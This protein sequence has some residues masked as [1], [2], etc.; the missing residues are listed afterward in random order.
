MVGATGFEPAT[1]PPP[2]SEAS[3]IFNRFEGL[4]GHFLRFLAIL[5]RIPAIFSGEIVAM[6]TLNAVHSLSVLFE[7]PCPI[8]AQIAF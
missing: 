8:D 1:S 6:G 5:K 3:V 7:K 4:R 2:V